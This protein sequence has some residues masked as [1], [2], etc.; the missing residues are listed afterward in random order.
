M[1]AQ[2]IERL[3]LGGALA[4]AV[5]GV[6]AVVAA[7]L[8]VEARPVLA[9]WL[10]AAF[11]RVCHQIAERSFHL[12]GHPLAVC[13]RCTGLYAGGL[14]GLVLLPRLS[15]IADR[16]L[17]SPRWIP[18]LALPLLADWTLWGHWSWLRFATGLLAA[19]PVTVLVQAAIRQLARGR[20]HRPEEIPA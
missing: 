6:A 12:A 8:L 3:A 16:L 10:Y 14:A 18:A 1:P 5:L 19:A 2:R 4:V 13:H 9:G 20:E 7:P 15:G 11:D 17:A